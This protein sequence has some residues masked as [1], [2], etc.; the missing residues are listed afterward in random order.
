[1]TKG[2]APAAATRPS[3]APEYRNLTRQLRRG[4]AG[5]TRALEE[6]CPDSVIQQSRAHL[7]RALDRAI[8]LAGSRYAHPP[9]VVY[10]IGA[11]ARKCRGSGV[12]CR[13]AAVRDMRE[14]VRFLAMDDPRC[15]VPAT[16]RVATR[17]A[18]GPRL[19]GLRRRASR[20]PAAWQ[21]NGHRPPDVLDR[22]SSADGRALASTRAAASRRFR[23]VWGPRRWVGRNSD[24]RP[25]HSSAKRI[26]SYAFQQ[27]HLRPSSA[28]W[29]R[30]RADRGSKPCVSCLVRA[31]RQVRS[32]QT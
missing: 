21:R 27:I 13:V 4:A 25:S 28:R 6:H 29:P 9:D 3:Y 18:T 32:A 20:G 8:T 19:P 23:S 12:A 5:L 7:D 15:R 14:R 26:R 1:M 17:A 31:T 24:T 22:V 16:V 2:E 10:G 11:S 30:P